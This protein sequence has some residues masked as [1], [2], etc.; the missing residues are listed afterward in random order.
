MDLHPYFQQLLDFRTV[1]SQLASLS[2]KMSSKGFASEVSGASEYPP[3]QL[4]FDSLA[5]FDL[6]VNSLIVYLFNLLRLS[7]SHYLVAKYFA[8]DYSY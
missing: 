4:A 6:Y 1:V 3:C 5:N 7:L 2:R 8:L